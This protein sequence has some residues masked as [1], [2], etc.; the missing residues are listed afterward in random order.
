MV[1]SKENEKRLQETQETNE[2]LNFYQLAVNSMDDYK[3]AIVDDNYRYKAV[4]K[5]YL[6]G[7]DL[8]RDDIEGWSIADLMGQESFEHAIKPF[9]DRALIKE[10]L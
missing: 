4:S 7:Y 3:T 10:K 9:L 5:Q 1:E 6:E 2:V 8:K